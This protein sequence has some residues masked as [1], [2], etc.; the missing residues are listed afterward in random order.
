MPVT[1]TCR[2]KGQMLQ[3]LSPA[4]ADKRTDVCL[5]RVGNGVAGR[6]FACVYALI[7]CS[8]VH[9]AGS[10]PSYERR[11]ISRFNS[12]LDSLKPRS[13]QALQAKRY[14]NNRPIADEPSHSRYS[15]F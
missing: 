4:D 3:G 6:T 11:N 15:E 7:Q 10:L 5:L 8:V 1:V 13:L 14:E 9:A 12:S 2:Q